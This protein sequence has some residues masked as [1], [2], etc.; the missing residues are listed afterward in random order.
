[1]SHSLSI[2]AYCSDLQTSIGKARLPAKS[3]GRCSSSV[4]VHIIT[5]LP[6]RLQSL[7]QC[8][9]CYAAVE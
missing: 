5:L 1:M 7:Y 9:R 3:K 2:Q 4:S 6:H 8:H